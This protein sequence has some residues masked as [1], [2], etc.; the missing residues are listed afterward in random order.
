MKKQQ[1]QQRWIWHGATLAAAVLAVLISIAAAVLGGLAFT[2]V[3]YHNGETLIHTPGA[4]PATPYP[5]Y[6][7]QAA[8]PLGMILPSTLDGRVGNVY[9]VWSL[10][11][12]PHT[13]SIAAGGGITWDGVNT[14][15][16]FGGA[17]G[18]GLV[19]EV[20]AKNKVVVLSVINVAFS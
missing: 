20:I 19:F 10:T 14:V 5:I 3:N 2:N 1:Q 9:R 6:L 4:L 11:A 13:I 8:A 16:T 17:I 12:Q 18:D 7:N 15:A